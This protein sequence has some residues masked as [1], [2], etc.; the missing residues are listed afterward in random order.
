M[1]KFVRLAASG[2]AG[3]VI[4]TAPTALVAA[5]PASAATTTV[6][7]AMRPAWPIVGQGARGQRVWAI[8]Y[9]LKARGYRLAADGKFGPATKTAV[10]MFQ[11]VMRLR[12]DGVVGP[13]TWSR[14]IITLWKGKRGWAVRG[15]QTNLRY[16]YGYRI[17][18]DGVFG[19]STKNAVLNFQ[20]RYRLVRDGIVGY[21]TWQALIWNER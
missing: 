2:L 15:L 8:Q 11:R 17:G 7:T 3:L 13:A 21:A 12:V 14:L 5:A 10:R 19:Q 18:I 4:I 16:A 9:L 6:R 1:R 20:R